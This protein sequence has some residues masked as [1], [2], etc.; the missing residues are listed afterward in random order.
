MMK[1]ALAML[2]ALALALTAPPTRADTIIF[3]DFG[4]MDGYDRSLGFDEAGPSSIFTESIR[5][6][7]FFTVGGTMEFTFDQ[8][9]LALILLSGI[10]QITLDLFDTDMMSGKPGTLLD[11]IS[12]T[13]AMS[14]SSPGSV[15]TFTST[16]HPLLQHGDTYWLLPLASTDT[17]AKWL[18]NNQG[19]LGT[20]AYSNATTPM[21]PSDWILE[22]SILGAFD[23]SGAPTAS[24]VPEPASLTLLGIA[25]VGMIGYGWR[26]RRLNGQRKG[27]SRFQ[28][29][30]L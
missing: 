27:H 24:G 8:A 9:R 19:M 20:E 7:S 13:N 1:H 17:Y 21:H 29:G 25:T 30:G 11:S 12:L 4:P 22:G 15:V 26:R 10:N 5:Q 16:M 2:A 6:A 14:N 23:V 28:G 18:V 3:S